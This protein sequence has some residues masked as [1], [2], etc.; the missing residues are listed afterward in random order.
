MANLLFL[1]V[2]YRKHMDILVCPLKHLFKVAAET[3]E[4]AG[5]KLTMFTQKFRL[6]QTAYFLHFHAS[7]DASYFV[8]KFFLCT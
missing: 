8:N 1:V 5:E 6:I 2:N 4:K 7:Y 3:G